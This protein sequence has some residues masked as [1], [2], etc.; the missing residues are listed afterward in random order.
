M[1]KVYCV[2]GYLHGIEVE[3]QGGDYIPVSKIDHRHYWNLSAKEIINIEEPK[4]RYFLHKI[5]EL[6]DFYIWNDD[7]RL[8]EN[9]AD[10]YIK[11]KI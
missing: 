2:G 1:S 5:G 7:S 9:L 8:K 10:N 4:D 6:R 3:M 11:G